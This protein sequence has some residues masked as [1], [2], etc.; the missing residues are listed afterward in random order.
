MAK[1]ERL[2]ARFDIGMDEHAKVMLLTDLAFRALIESTMYARR[3]LTDGF[4]SEG[5]VLKKWGRDVA[6]ELTSNHPE[7]PSWVR[8][9]GGWQIRDYEKHQ[10][11]NA[12]IEA[13]REA[14]RLGGIARAERMASEKL[15]RASE[16]LKQKGGTNLAKTETETETTTP[17]GVVPRKRGTRIPEPFIVTGD[18]RAWAATRVPG[19]NVDSSTEKFA[20]YWRAKT[21]DATKLN[22]RATW[23]NWLISDFEKGSGHGTPAKPSKADRARQVIAQGQRLQAEIDRRELE[24]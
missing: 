15:A 8:V 9:E 1:D 16:V 5:V 21:R 20:N 4:L 7:R 19:V 23:D 17:K 18:M 2:Y 10:T 11:T 13:K 22:W 14:G 3:Q 24:A 6:P 12:D